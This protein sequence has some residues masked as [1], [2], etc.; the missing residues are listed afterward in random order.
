MNRRSTIEST[1]AVASAAFVAAC[2]ATSA[3]PLIPA[4]GNA[5][6]SAVASPS[7]GSEAPSS[8][9]RIS[10]PGA[11]AVSAVRL[12]IGEGPDRG[13]HSMSTARLHCLAQDAS[14]HV[15]A[16][17]MASPG[18]SEIEVVVHGTASGAPRFRFFGAFGKMG[19][20]DRRAYVLLGDG[21]ATRRSKGT[22][23]IAN[24]GKGA[25]LEIRGTTVDGI[26]VDL[27]VDCE[28]VLRLGSA[29]KERS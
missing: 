17:D 2:T 1:I 5:V 11:P 19:R 7:R 13:A 27:K 16:H 9:T 6:E 26:A 29:A 22:L 21:Y 20:P 12:E 18:F 15:Y 24:R 4:I 23:S 25:S 8:E 3:L 10:E 28:D 14:W